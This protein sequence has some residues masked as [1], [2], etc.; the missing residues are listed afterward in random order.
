MTFAIRKKCVIPQ[1]TKPLVAIHV[2]TIGRLT[3]SVFPK[4]GELVAPLCE[5][6]EGVFEEGHDNEEAA[7]GR[8]IAVTRSVC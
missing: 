3:A 7:N 6:P 1:G 5:D 8:E 2:R 4:V